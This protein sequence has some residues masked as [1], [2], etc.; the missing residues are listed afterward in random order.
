MLALAFIAVAFMPALPSVAVAFTLTL[1]LT[2]V[3]F[4]LTP[5]LA[6]VV[7]SV[8]TFVTQLPLLKRAHSSQLVPLGKVH[9]P[10][11]LP[12]AAVWIS[13]VPPMLPQ[14]TEAGFDILAVNVAVTAAV[15]AS[16]AEAVATVVA[17]T[18]GTV[19][20]TADGACC[21][22]HPA[23]SKPAM[24]QAPRMTKI[25]VLDIIIIPDTI[26][27]PCIKRSSE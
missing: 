2:A 22:V 21:C 4:M 15:G 24:M 13:V 8:V 6:G 10:Y 18:V 1:A 23:T 17:T 20:W 14:L 19:V 5:A 12:S 3:V 27:M 25:L 26:S 16:V 11:W 7:A 9:M